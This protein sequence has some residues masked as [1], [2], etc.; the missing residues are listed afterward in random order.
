LSLKSNLKLLNY[1]FELP[2]EERKNT[3]PIQCDVNG[4]LSMQYI[5]TALQEYHKKRNFVKTPEPQGS[6]EQKSK[7]DS[8]LSFVVQ[9]HDATR[10]EMFLD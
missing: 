4:D 2:L 6:T 8:D 9:K 5:A 3:N 7:K 1:Y 10:Y